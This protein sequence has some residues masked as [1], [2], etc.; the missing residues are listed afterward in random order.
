VKIPDRSIRFPGGQE[1]VDILRDL[2]AFAFASRLKRL[3]DR[4]KSEVSQTYHEQGVDFSDSWFLVGYMLS[5]NDKL[6][7]TDMADALGISP[8]AIS[9]ISSVMVK[10][11]LIRVEKGRD[12][13]RKRMLLLTSKGRKTIK[14]LEPIWAAVTEC[15]EVLITETGFDM[16]GAIGA[17]ERGLEKKDMTERLRERLG[18]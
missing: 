11:G 2:G 14:A 10:K 16:L 7:V 6:T 5:K 3:S 8:P 15:T 17:M 13:K 18:K 1:L 4:L 12:D 9:Q